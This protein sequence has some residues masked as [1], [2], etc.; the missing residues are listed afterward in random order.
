MERPRWLMNDPNW[1]TNKNYI[2]ICSEN[3]FPSV[4]PTDSFIVCSDNKSVINEKVQK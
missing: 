2:R 3:K 1:I 4:V